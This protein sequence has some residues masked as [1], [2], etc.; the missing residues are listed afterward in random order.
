MLIRPYAA[1]DA[2]RLLAIFNSAVH[3]TA[4]A[5]YSHAQRHAWAPL[6][7]ELGP[8]TARMDALAPWVLESGGTAWAY[9]SLDAA[10]YIDHF[11]VHGSQAR[12]G[13][14]SHLMAHVLATAHTQC[15]PTLSADVSRTAQPFFARHGFA[16][17]EERLPVRAGIVIPNALMRRHLHLPR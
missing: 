9:A 16:V 10:G 1:Q 8:W 6:D 15:L 11:F 5:D 4:A 14:G 12:Q 17:V 3:T 7:R 13:L 2:A